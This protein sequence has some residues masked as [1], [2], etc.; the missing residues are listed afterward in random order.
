MVVGKMRNVQ[1]KMRYAKI[2]RMSMAGRS[3]L[4]MKRLVLHVGCYTY[5]RI[6]FFIMLK[7]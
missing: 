2:C 6:K 5:L 7:T 4:Y 1:G 3:I